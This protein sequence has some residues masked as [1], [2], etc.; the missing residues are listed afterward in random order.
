MKTAWRRGYV[1]TLVLGAMLVWPMAAQAKDKG[2]T[3]EQGQAILDELRQIRTLLEKQQTQA[4]A[5]PALREGSG[6]QQAAQPRNVKV[7][8]EGSYAMG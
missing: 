8:I 7:S 2:M 3:E 1:G 4:V 5:R 6:S